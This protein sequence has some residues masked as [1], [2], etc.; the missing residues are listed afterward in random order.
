MISLESFSTFMKYIPVSKEPG[1]V[2]AAPEL[3]YT[4]IAVSKTYLP[5]INE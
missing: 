5:A 2:N 4:L 1:I 3:R